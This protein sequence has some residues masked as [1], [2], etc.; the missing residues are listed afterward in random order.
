MRPWIVPEKWV[1]RSSMDR[2][3]ILL[4]QQREVW[5]RDPDR[6]VI[7]PARTDGE[8]GECDAD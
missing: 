5:L 7:A 8:T 4:P 3:S 6:Y 2:P 1:P